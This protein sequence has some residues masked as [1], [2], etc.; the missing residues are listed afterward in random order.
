MKNLKYN[1][2]RR[3]LFKGAGTL[4]ALALTGTNADRARAE[5]LLAGRDLLVD[6]RPYIQS[7]GP[8]LGCYDPYGD[9]SDES[10]V[11]TEHL[12][13][14]WEDVE[15]SG[16]PAADEYALARNR[17]VLVT[18]EPWSWDLDWNVSSPELR[19][20]IL[21]GKHDA[22]MRAICEILA[23]F[24]SPVT[25]RWAQEMENP[26]GRFTWSLWKPEDY[27]EAYRRM[28]RIAK[29]VAPKADMMWSPKGLETAKP[30]Y[31][32][33]EYVDLV[34]LSVFGYDKYEKIEYGRPRSFAEDL[35]LG[36]ETTVGFGKPI[37]IAELGYE[38]ELDYLEKWVLDVTRKFPE[39]P[40]LKE[41]IY[42]NDKE[43]WAWP[44]RLGLP[45]WRVVRP[46]TNYPVRPIRG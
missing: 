22:N 19:Q 38:G 16:L 41:V 36:Y 33:D 5:D 30:Y 1:L 18:I 20:A 14:P 12:F 24:K 17:K 7:D 37:W 13:L 39:Y 27:I 9:F 8:K 11:A 3:S 45:D 28:F 35:K 25:I 40:E 46:S 15:L 2:S 4:A 44:H 43:V 42:F 34:G 23:T 31:P 6:K 10:R 32:G 21:S 26:S 29:E